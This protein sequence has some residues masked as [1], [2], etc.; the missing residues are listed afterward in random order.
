MATRKSSAVKIPMFNK[1]N[2]GH[3]KKKMLLYI[4]VANPLYMKVLTDG[5][6]PIMKS[7][8]TIDD[9]GVKTTTNVEN[10]DFST[11]SS[12]QKEIAV[13]D[14]NLQLILIDSL[15]ETMVS[16]VINCVDAR[17]I[18]KTIET[19][20]E[21]TDEVRENKMEILMSEYEHF[22]SGHN[23]GITAVFERYNKLINKLNLA[24]K[25]YSTR[26][27]NK[28]FLNSMP[29]HLEHRITA[30]RESRDINTISLDKLYGILKT[31][32]LEQ[33]QKKDLR[34]GRKVASSSA[35]YGEDSEVVERSPRKKAAEIVR[36]HSS[37]MDKVTVEHGQTN[38][39]EHSQSEYYSLEELDQ[40]EDESMA[41]LVRN[42][43]NKFRFKRNPKFR[44]KSNDR[45]QK[46]SFGPSSTSRGG[47]KTGTVNRS[48]F[49]CFNCNELG[50]FASEC[51]KPKQEKKSA[52][53]QPTQ[54]SKGKA[55]VADEGKS[56][57]D[58]ESEE[59]EEEHVNYALMAD[60]E[61][62]VIVKSKV[63]SDVDMIRNLSY[64]LQSAQTTVARVDLEN[65]ALVKENV[66]L[67]TVISNQPIL[68]EKIEFLEN[69]VNI[70]VKMETILRTQIA[71]HKT[72]IAELQVKVNAY[73]L[74]V[75]ASKSYFTQAAVDKT[76]GIGFDYNKAIGEPSINI[77]SHVANP[78]MP[79]PQVIRGTVEPV[80][81]KSRVEPL[82]CK[83]IVINEEMRTEDV[84]TGNVQKNNLSVK[85]DKR[86]SKNKNKFVSSNLNYESEMKAYSAEIDESVPE[87][88]IKDV[89]LINPLKT[90]SDSLIS[91]PV[92]NTSVN[93]HAMPII[94]KSHKACSLTG[95]MSCAFNIMS[96]YFSS[97]HS[98]SDRTAPRQHMNSKF[99]K[100]VKPRTASPPRSRKDTCVVQRPKTASPS[101][102]GQ[103]RQSPKLKQLV[104]K[105]V[106][107][108]K[109]PVLVKDVI[110]KIKNVVLPDK[111]QFFKCAGPNQVWVRKK[112]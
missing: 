23:E 46:G 95:C 106:Y 93:I 67:K 38:R 89:P 49:R 19:I 17:H 68:S 87:V 27:V 51:K 4:R 62:S 9:A 73:F 97:N 75:K 15:D 28:K 16:Q 78:G 94:D 79:V 47:Y 58:T 54:K 39:S 92:I 71:D 1:E 18:W 8:E 57:D 33:E 101:M 41:M 84:T 81:A 82:N 61:S 3:W 32:E 99:V 21:G 53:V 37:D 43:G 111:G 90:N 24:G 34:S 22:Q 66:E 6:I 100:S 70:Y 12:E 30:I 10:K 64:A 72:K 77:P 2:F 59:E 98:S 25:F 74:T 103:I 45:F 108:V 83:A 86:S 7:V 107:R 56:W 65:A 110:I 35:L 105:V 52:Y 76:F 48:K 42:F 80:Y 69:R 109:C 112:V 14:D 20:C 5:P 26:E 13:L 91:K 104:E 50:H 11:F 102:T 55:Y 29:D 60:A 88:V 63:M 96:A 44:Y 36:S 40:L 85:A 31:Y